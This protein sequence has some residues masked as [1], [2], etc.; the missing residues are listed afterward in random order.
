MIVWRFP[1]LSEPFVLNQIAGLLDRGHD[2]QIYALNGL[3]DGPAKTHPIVER[4]ALAKRAHLAPPRGSGNARALLGL[5]P[6]LAGPALRR[7]LRFVRLLG[8]IARGEWPDPVKALGRATVLL[9]AGPF[10]VVHCQFGNLA[11]PVMRFRAAGMLG[12]RLVTI[13]RGFD[14]SRYVAEQGP[15]VY[16]ELFAQGDFFLANCEFF[17]RRAIELGC[18]A[19]RI[20][21]HGSGI[22]VERFEFRARHFPESGPVRVATT[23]RLV[24]K[25][26]MEYA[27]RAVAAL[28]AQ[29]VPVHLSIIGDGPLR[30]PFEALIGELG[31]AERVELLGWRDQR[32]IIGILDRC[33]LFVAPSVTAADGNQDAPVNTLKEAMAM[34]LPVVATH[35]GGIPELVEDGVSGLLVSERDGEAIA[36]ALHV[37]MANAASW[38][39][40]GAAGRAAV[41][42]MFDMRKLNDE[43][44]AV[45]ERLLAQP[46][47]SDERGFR[48]DAIGRV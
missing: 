7:P 1:V 6:R 11:P 46:D 32:E 36:A 23:G 8:Q 12:G 14:I 40:M 3:P 20:V 15:D 22:D 19:E 48:H 33:H 2:V 24:E 38:P 16:D 18:P 27:I 44:V 21:V 37:L 43:I 41:E 10:D 30:A 35:H 28:G 47:R 42:R 5:L 9:D 29:G 17:R 4:Y 39:Q 31:C 34:G 26:G 25:K 45:Y 13:F